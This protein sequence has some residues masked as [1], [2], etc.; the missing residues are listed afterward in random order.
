M[1]QQ[2][3]LT[4]FSVADRFLAG[5][6]ATRL[7]IGF[8]DSDNHELD[9]LVQSLEFDDGLETGL[10]L[11]LDLADELLDDLVMTRND[12]VFQTVKSAK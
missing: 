2:N 3:S 1:W 12:R 5:N 9:E 7:P 6:V 4:Q 10:D 11:D 8:T